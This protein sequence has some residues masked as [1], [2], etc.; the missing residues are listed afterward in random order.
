MAS[1]DIECFRLID[2]PAG[3]EQVVRDTLT[4][5]DYP[6]EYLTPAIRKD[7][8]GACL[9][10]WNASNGPGG[11]TGNFWGTYDID[12]SMQFTDWADD[13]PFVLT[14]EIGHMVDWA[15]FTKST[16]AELTKIFHAGPGMSTPMLVHSNSGQYYRHPNEDWSDSVNNDYIARLNECFADEFVAT[17]APGIWNGTVLGQ[18]Q[19][20]PRFVHWSDK[21][22]T[23][24]KIT[25]TAGAPTQEDPAMAIVKKWIYAEGADLLAAMSVARGTNASV[26]ISRTEAQELVK[27]GV[28][29]TIIGGPAC[30][31][32]GLTWA[33]AGKSI[34]KGAITTCLGSTYADSLKLALG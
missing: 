8:D 21:F 15:T 11:G 34:T 25:L 1:V 9:I 30:K 6:W 19:H 7:L 22:D 10:H 29:I 33:E 20:W 23:I 31:S 17:F 24:R 27:A 26:V 3:Q 18:H 32:L 5:I 2:P 4:Q 16:R 13:I 12:L 28:T 14:H